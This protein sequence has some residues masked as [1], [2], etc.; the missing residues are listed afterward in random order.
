M[1]ILITGAAG[2][3]GYLT[4]LALSQRGHFVYLTVHTKKEEENL[5]ERL[6]DIKNIEVMKIDI[7]NELD[8]K[9]VLSLNIDCLF[10][11]AAVGLG[12]SIIEADMDKV[13]KSFEVNVFSS[14]SLLQMVLRQMVDK[15][16]GRIIVMSSLAS[17]FTL[18]FIG[19]Y[20]STKASISSIT[21]SLQKELFL[22]GTNV[23]VI[24][25]EPGLYHTG[26]NQV[27]LDNKYDEGK[28]FSHIKEELNNVEH[29][30]VRLGEKEKLDSIVVKIV[31]AIEDEK[32][33][34]VYRAPF[35]Q[36][37]LAR[38]YNILKK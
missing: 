2:G 16:S 21:K 17:T 13:R 3:I 7:T 8:R 24:L 6:K 38:I 19:I 29:F 25:I 37:K 26:F 32:P 27:F 36:S 4:A 5:K 22:M 35:I 9:K 23:K 10:N 33:K 1:K 34:D 20:S 30:L 14:F 15:D 18:P 12:G 31:R 28:Y 11:N